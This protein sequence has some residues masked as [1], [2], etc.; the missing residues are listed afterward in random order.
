M[1]KE[2]QGIQ[3]RSQRDWQS[4]VDQNQRATAHIKEKVQ[5]KAPIYT[6]LNWRRSLEV[7]LAILRSGHAFTNEYKHSKIDRRTN[8][9][10]RK[11]GQEKETIEHLLLKCQQ[12]HRPAALISTMEALNKKNWHHMKSSNLIGTNTLRQLKQ[13]KW[14][15]G[16]EELEKYLAKLKTMF[17]F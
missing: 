4:E 1:G 2:K 15:R 7:S 12:V 17:Q 14:R 8:P 9:Y 11:C 13:P 10:C 6:K 5:A 16:R 3:G